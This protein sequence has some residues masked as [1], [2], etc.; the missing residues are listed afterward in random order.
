MTATRYPPE[1]APPGLPDV[2]TG[3]VQQLLRLAKRQGWDE[4]NITCRR[5]L[6]RRAYRDEQ[7]S[8][9]GP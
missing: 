8:R 6:Q 3:S 7:R 2:T 9:F 5:E 4:V 1:D